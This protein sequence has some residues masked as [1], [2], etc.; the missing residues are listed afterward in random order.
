MFV[1]AK[2]NQTNAAKEG[3]QPMDDLKETAR[4]FKADTREAA[5]AMKDDLEDAA[6][7]TGR[8]ARDIVDSAGHSLSGAGEVLTVKI[9]DNPVQSSLIALGVGI[10]LGILFKKR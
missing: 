9:R 1:A 4:H 10:V 2:D 6:R 8:H 7:R 3:A 5:S